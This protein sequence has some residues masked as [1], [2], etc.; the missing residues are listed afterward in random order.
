MKTAT[1]EWEDETIAIAAEQPL[2]LALLE[3]AA[4][5]TSGDR[6]KAYGAPVP[7][8]HHIA[9]IFNAI[10]GHK[11]TARDVAL[12]HVATK[13]ARLYGNATHRDSHV[14]GMAYLGIAFEC[15]MAAESPP[16]PET[17]PQPIQEGFDL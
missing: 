17:R 15:A 2:R 3:E 9:D 1:H 14:D 10:S 13:L 11:V 4:T 7:N 12:F 5:L 16:T 8:M 6:N